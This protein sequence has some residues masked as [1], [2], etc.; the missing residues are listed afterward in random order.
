M[1]KR[2]ESVQEYLDFAKEINSDPSYHIPIYSSD[3]ELFTRLQDAPSQPNKLVLGYFQQD[4]ILGLFVFFVEGSQQYLEML[5]SFSRL[6]E[7]YEELLAFLKEQY[8]GWQCDFVY[9]PG[10]LFLHSQ[11]ERLAAA[12]DPEQQKMTLA[13]ETAWEGKPQ[14]E[15]YSPRRREGYTA[16]H[17]KDMY[18]TAEKILD[19]P[20]RFRVILAVEEGEVVGYIDITT[21]YEEN[22]PFH[23]FVKESHRRK[24]WARAMLAKAIELNRPKAMALTVNVDNIP[25]IA[26]YASMGFVKVNGQNSITAHV[27]L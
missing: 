12:F 11:L 24:G 6:P 21:N 27:S 14:A 20:E 1:I 9:N 7:A 18:W 25:A 8:P 26:L 23:V 17:A 19:A 2:L 16:I 13:R 22:E 15:L 5:M 3:K 10:N 4:T